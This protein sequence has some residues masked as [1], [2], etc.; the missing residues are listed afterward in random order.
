MFCGAQLMC[1]INLI[2]TAQMNQLTKA[3]Q[4]SLTI[5]FTRV[6]HSFYQ[7]GETPTVH[8]AGKTS[9]RHRHRHDL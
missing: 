6:T 2:R 1:E 4:P 3:H 5:S 7:V 8:K 9:H